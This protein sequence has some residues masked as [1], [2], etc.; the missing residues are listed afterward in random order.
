[1]SRSA[2]C[3][4]TNSRSAHLGRST[5]AGCRK[6][7]HS[8]SCESRRT[9]FSSGPIRRHCVFPEPCNRRWSVQRPE[10]RR[11]LK[12]FAAPGVVGPTGS[13]RNRAH[14]LESAANALCLSTGSRR[15]WLWIRVRVRSKGRGD[16]SIR[17]LLD[18][19]A[20]MDKQDYQLWL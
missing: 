13:P 11:D 16:P 6:S 18:R 1:M 20:L 15:A 17:V 19:K 9:L 3:L 7:A 2:L 8:D 12:H 10:H 5:E 14:R 4:V